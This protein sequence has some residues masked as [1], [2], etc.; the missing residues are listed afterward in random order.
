MKHWGERLRAAIKKAKLSQKDVATRLGRSEQAVSKWCAG[1]GIRTDELK[2]L[3]RLLG[4]NWIVLRYGIDESEIETPEAMAICMD[5][6]DYAKAVVYREMTT[7]WKEITSGRTEAEQTAVLILD[8][9]G[10]GLWSKCLTTGAN[11][12]SSVAKH[13]MSRLPSNPMSPSEIRDAVWEQR[14][15]DD[16]LRHAMNSRKTAATVATNKTNG[17][18]LFFLTIAYGSEG[19]QVSRLIGIVVDYATFASFTNQLVV[20]FEHLL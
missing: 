14:K 16:M 15:I 8:M 13:L 17:S 10:I 4:V 11:F 5:G 9:L 2:N 1:G 18:K 3:A 12:V 6:C 7:L 19:E 20:D